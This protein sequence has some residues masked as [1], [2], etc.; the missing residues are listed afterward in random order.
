MKKL[1]NRFGLLFCMGGLV[2]ASCSKKVTTVTPDPP[3]INPIADYTVTPDPTDGF[4]FKFNNLSKNY[5]KSK[6]EWRFGD[7]TLNTTESPSHTFLATGKYVTDLKIYSSTGTYSH[8]YTNINIIPDSVLKISAVKTGTP[9]ELALSANFKGTIKSILWTFNDVDPSTSNTTTVKYTTPSVTRK[10]I[11]G[12][13][14]SFSVTVTSDKGSTVTVSS[15]IT[16]DGIVTDITQSR[17]NYDSTNHNLVQGPNE[18]YPKLID[19]NP[20]T[21]FGY[22]SAFPVPEIFWLQFAAPVTVKLYAIENGNDSDSNR[23]PSE[24]VIEGSNDST[25]GVSTG[26]WDILDHRNA[27][28]TDPATMMTPITGKGFADYLS[29]I[30]QSATRYKRFFYYPI[31]NPKPYTY[32]RW[33]I[34][35]TF[36]TAFQIEELRF[37]K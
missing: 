29:A 26:I 18:D 14:N 16:T 8:K 28:S 13:F 6:I 5:D 4:T 2:L 21:K 33:R 37:Y 32:Y 12:S 30:G 20:S 19:G 25:N 23:D 11:Y 27:N 7:D 17:I 3:V 35:S 15:N 24:W 22:Y 9:F 1:S 34:I 36:K 10:F 31:A